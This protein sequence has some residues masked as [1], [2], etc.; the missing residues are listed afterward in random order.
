M[1][2]DHTPRPLGTRVR[3]ELAAEA[4]QFESFDPGVE[5]VMERGAAR[6][7][8]NTSIMVGVAAVAVLGTAVTAVS[9][10]KQ[11]QRGDRAPASPTGTRLESVQ[12]QGQLLFDLPAATEG[13][14]GITWD[15]VTPTST[16]SGYGSYRDVSH[17]GASVY[18]L[19][20]APTIN[21]APTK[22]QV[23]HTGDGIEFQPSGAPLDDRWVTTLSGDADDALY[24]LGTAPAGGS[25]Q[26]IGATST[27]GGNTWSDQPLPVDVA[28][29]KEQ[30][31][32]NARFLP[33]T[34]AAANGVAVALLTPVQSSFPGSPVIVPAGVDA[35]FGGEVRADG[36]AVYDKPDEDALKDACPPGSKLTQ[37]P[38]GIIADGPVATTISFGPG[39]A[40]GATWFCLDNAGTIS[41]VPPDLIHG[42]V[43]KV[44]P[45]ADLGLS[46]DSVLTLQQRPR[47]FVS[48]AGGAWVEATLPGDASGVSENAGSTQLIWTGDS[49]A[50]L[51]VTAQGPR[52][53]TSPD[54]TAWIERT[55]P[56]IE[57]PALVSLSNGTLLLSGTL[58]LQ[59]VAYTS[60]DATTWDGVALDPLLQLDPA[61]RIVETRLVSGPVGA[62]VLLSARRDEIAAA[63]GLVLDHGR[64][65]LTITDWMGGLRLTDGS[66]TVLDEMA[67]GFNFGATPRDGLIQPT[68]D[69]GFDVIDPDTG[70]RLDSFSAAE[71]SNAQNAEQQRINPNGVDRQ[72]P[73]DTWVLDTVD[74]RTWQVTRLG[75]MGI[76]GNVGTRFA[77]AT[78]DT[79]TFGFGIFNPLGATTAITVVGRRA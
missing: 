61:W 15:A 74:G 52:L 44:I 12:D 27:D 24:A 35:P 30:L 36:Y 71:V 22:Q 31:G 39:G 10:I 32:S 26:Y 13:A 2:P 49:F 33:P 64:L 68:G 73:S 37:D 40:Q 54:G 16:L 42:E 19:G 28:S 8:R 77:F 70:E 20:T 47:V 78:A 50:L 17:N 25:F 5:V 9:F 41:M 1:E 18:A 23:F 69:G 62:A 3:Q 65:R 75:P 6:R 21:G 38:K 43:T 66:G 72:Q 58:G 53:W 45:F 60:V 29:I 14:T 51:L 46:A 76:G 63:G 79:V 55:L 59:H 4:R 67:L 56:A 11:H 7:R 57:S 34:L 48:T